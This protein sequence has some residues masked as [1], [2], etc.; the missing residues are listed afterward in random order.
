MIDIFI[1]LLEIILDKPLKTIATKL[2]L[3]WCILYAV[4]LIIV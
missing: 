4:I 3:S 1:D 2:L